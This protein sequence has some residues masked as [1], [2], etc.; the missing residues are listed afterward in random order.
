[1]EKRIYLVGNA[2][3]MWE[4]KRMENTPL[5]NLAF[6][7]HFLSFAFC[8]FITSLIISPYVS[9]ASS[10]F[11]HFMMH[12]IILLQLLSPYCIFRL[13]RSSCHLTVRFIT[14]SPIII[15]PCYL[16][17]IILLSFHSFVVRRSPLSLVYLSLFYSFS[18]SGTFL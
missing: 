17:S 6:L 2:L 15:S 18:S 13:L 14:Q 1:M 4:K 12:F 16:T 3:L 9:V 5:L 11:Y 8:H 7:Y 10:R